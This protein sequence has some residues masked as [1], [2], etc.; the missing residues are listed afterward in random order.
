MRLV[1]SECASVLVHRTTK[2]VDGYGVLQ[3]AP[4]SQRPFVPEHEPLKGKAG[5]LVL[6]TSCGKATVL[7]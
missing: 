6:D 2:Y 7:K 3:V 1:C 4:S 5:A